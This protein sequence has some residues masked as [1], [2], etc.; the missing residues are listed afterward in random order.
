ML[1]QVRQVT[2]GVDKIL[3][4]HTHSLF[5]SNSMNNAKELMAEFRGYLANAYPQIEPNDDDEAGDKIFA[6]R[7]KPY[8]PRN[9]SYIDLDNTLRYSL[10][11]EV[12]RQKRFNIT[13]FRVLRQNFVTLYRYFPF[14]NENVRRLF[15]RM[16]IWFLKERSNMSAVTYIEAMRISDGFLKPKEN[17]F[18]CNGSLPHYRG[19][20]CG[21]WTLFHTLTVS[22]YQNYTKRN[23]GEPMVHEVLPTMVN[24]ITNFYNCRSCRE[25]FL[26]L[27]EGMSA[28]LAHANSSILWLW[29]VHNLVNYRLHGGLNEDPFHPKIQFPSREACPTCYCQTCA[30]NEF[31][32]PEVLEF[33]LRYY[34]RKTIVN[35]SGTISL[36]YLTLISCISLAWF[37]PH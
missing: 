13:Q 18:H 25:Y 7:T 28:E 21:L 22:E 16:N 36:G 9:L 23:Q 31:V 15:K 4:K 24:Y 19:Y 33:L 17:W 6:R 32:L 12:S 5:M 14:R 20:P 27:S 8:V 30:D 37:L 35:S 11:H 29:R 10:L 34:D 2:S 26:R 3:N 1:V